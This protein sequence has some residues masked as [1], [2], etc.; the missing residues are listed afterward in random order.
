MHIRRWCLL[1][2]TL[3]ILANAEVYRWTDGQGRSHYSDR[4]H[5]DA[6]VLH[7]DSGISCG[8]RAMVNIDYAGS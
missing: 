5:A 6:Q 3:P 2:V 1:A 4:N 7:I 8:F